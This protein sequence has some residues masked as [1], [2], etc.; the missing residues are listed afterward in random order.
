MLVK[1][2]N[3]WKHLLSIED[4]ERL[5]ALLASVGKHKGAYRNAEDI[6]TAQLWC[7][8]LELRKENTFL[9]QRLM[10]LESKINGMNGKEDSD[11]L[12]KSLKKL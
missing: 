8:L 3:D 7:A 11:D 6:K 2:D 9:L 10:K 1:T 5:N 12:L 4:E